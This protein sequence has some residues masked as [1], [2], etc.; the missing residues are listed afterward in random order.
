[1]IFPEIVLVI[2]RA[3]A[4]RQGCAIVVGGAARA[5]YARELAPKDHDLEVFGLAPDVVREVLS[6]FGTVDLVGAQF[7]VFKIH[8]YPDIDVSLPRRDSCTGAGHRDFEVSIDPHMTYKEAARRRDFTMNAIGV[9]PL[10]GEVLDPYQG[11]VDIRLKRLREVDS[12]TFVEDPLR[13]YR[14][15]QFCARLGISPT[16]G[17]TN[18]LTSM[19]IDDK[20][21]NL[22]GERVLVEL[23]KLM[24][25]RNA[26]HGWQL[27]DAWGM[28]DRSQPELMSLMGCQQDTVYHPEGDVWVHSLLTLEEAQVAASATG[29]D[30]LMAWAA[31][32]HDFGKPT[33]TFVE[34]ERVKS[35]GHDVAGIEPVRSFFTRFPGMPADTV[36]KIAM[37][38]KHH[39]APALFPAQGAGR[40]AYMRLA[41][42]LDSVGLSL[43]QLY[44]VNLADHYGRTTPDALA[45]QH[46]KGEAF[47]AKAGEVHATPERARGVVMGRHLIAKGMKPG[48]GFR[49]IL[50]KCQDYQDDT[51]EVSPDVILDAVMRAEKEAT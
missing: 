28:I 26:V 43:H 35:P 45:Y 15:A 32:C 42:D 11:I 48:V 46:P 40:R 20:H 49:D 16:G 37:L 13:M 21:H 18:L 6:N 29:D 5:E 10:T 17:L 12:A 4:A 31:L 34:G 51:A 23:R 19:A 1:M 25:S 47:L 44:Q 9:N 27:L 36:D 33:T 7:G 3:M 38:T 8:E 30:E 50:Q 41:R 24:R 2:A 14:A 39:L 22:P